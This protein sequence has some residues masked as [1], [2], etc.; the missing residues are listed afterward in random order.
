M[1]GWWGFTYY[2]YGMST[3]PVGGAAELTDGHGDGRLRAFGE[4]PQHQTLGGRQVCWWVE[5]SDKRTLPEG[6]RAQAGNQ[7]GPFH[8]YTHLLT[9][10]NTCIPA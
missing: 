7:Y 10:T 8:T 1:T 9:H 2:W 5:D 4:G 6:G 3:L